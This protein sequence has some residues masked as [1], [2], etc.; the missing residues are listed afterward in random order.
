MDYY[1][2]QD[3]QQRGPFSVEQLRSQRL[4]PKTYVWY[5]GLEDW[6]PIS[7]VPALVAQL[8]SLPA[9]APASAANVGLTA[10]LPVPKGPLAFL[11]S[12]ADLVLL[13]VLIL[14]LVADLFNLA[15]MTIAEYG[16]VGFTVVSVLSS[17]VWVLF[18]LSAVALALLIRDRT[19][20][21]PAVVIAV[22]L[23]LYS[24][25]SAVRYAVL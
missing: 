1:L 18:S 13:M 25:F 22:I 15:L 21:T 3:D 16:S 7:E 6:R 12:R 19:Y 4:S 2:F 10:I 11:Q 5:D 14:W 17:V 23:G 9:Q 20:R 8:T 24:C